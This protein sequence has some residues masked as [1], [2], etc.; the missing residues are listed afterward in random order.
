MPPLSKA[1]CNDGG[2]ISGCGD[3]VRKKE[4]VI[5]SQRRWLTIRNAQN[6]NPYHG[7]PPGALADLADFYKARIAALRS[8][9]PSLLKTEIPEEYEWLRA[10]APAGLSKNEFSIGRAYAGCEDPCRKKPSLYRWISIGGRGIGNGAGDVDTPYGQLAKRLVSQGWTKCRSADDSG[11]PTIDYFAKGNK[12]VSVSR[13]YSMGVGNGIGI[14]ITISGPLPQVPPEPPP[15]PAV[16]IA[17]DWMTYSDD[18]VG[19][20][21]RYPPHWHIKDDTP[22]NSGMQ[23]KSLQFGADNYAPGDFRI[24]LEPQES[25]NLESR[26]NQLGTRCFPSS[27]RISGF[28]AA[29]CVFENEVVSVGVCERHVQSIVV[30]TGKF[31][32]TFEPALSGSFGDDSG[33]YTLLNLYERIMSTIEMKQPN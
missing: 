17:D 33:R 26:S 1:A 27:Y 4:Q 24:T 2:P 11:K 30:Q 12:I 14:G 23:Y 16:V 29:E 9:N 18:D 6:V 7:D 28:S 32:L 20:R 5:V 15:N 13:Y 8:N 3:R 22:P 19:L 21:L 25:V 10:I 31:D